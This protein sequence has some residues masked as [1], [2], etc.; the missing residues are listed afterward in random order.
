MSDR[1]PTLLSTHILSW[2]KGTASSARVAAQLELLSFQVELIETCQNCNQTLSQTSDGT[3]TRRVFSTWSQDGLGFS[4]HG[5][6]Q[7]DVV[8]GCLRGSQRDFK[9]SDRHVGG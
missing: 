7:V 4:V 6:P 1:D 3:L 5:Y 2:P 8:P 9:V